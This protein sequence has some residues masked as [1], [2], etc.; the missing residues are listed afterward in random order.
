MNRRKPG[1]RAKVEVVQSGD[2]RRCASL[3]V[4]AGG[5][6]RKIRRV[7]APHHAGN[8]P[9]RDGNGDGARRI[10]KRVRLDH[11]A[12]RTG[13]DMCAMRAALIGP[14]GG[15][16][17]IAV[18]NFNRPQRIGGNEGGGPARP[19]RCQNLHRQRDQKD[20]QKCP[21]PLP[22]QLTNSAHRHLIIKHRH[23]RGRAHRARCDEVGSPSRSSSL[24]EHDLR[25][26]AFRVCREGK[27]LRTFP[28]HALDGASSLGCYIR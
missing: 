21:Q 20:R 16:S 4:G 25:A 23:C 26:N 2:S 15:R 7:V 10:E 14:I 28:D 8:V 18:A 5:S 3:R 17:H 24:F 27:P 9:V 1:G 12:N 6:P 22:H 13:A 19:D 11:A